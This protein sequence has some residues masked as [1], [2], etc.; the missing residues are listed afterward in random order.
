MVKCTY[1]L[2]ELKKG[3]GMMYVHRIGTIEYYCSNSC[4]QN[5]VVMRKKINRKLVTSEV[6]IKAATTAKIAEKPQKK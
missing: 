5:H 6:K 2:S 4:F 1:C 3:T